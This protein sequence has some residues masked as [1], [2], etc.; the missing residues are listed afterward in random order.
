MVGPEERGPEN[1]F[2]PAKPHSPLP[3]KFSGCLL[4]TSPGVTGARKQMCP[5]HKRQEGDH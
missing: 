3:H 4:H 2:E 1:L 5:S